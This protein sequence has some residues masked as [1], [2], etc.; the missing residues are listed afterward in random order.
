M[1]DVAARVKFSDPRVTA[2][3]EERASVALQALE[4]LWFNTGTLCNITCAHCYIESS[5]KNDRLGY[6]SVEDV[7]AYLDEIERDGLGTEEIGFTGGEPFMNPDI[8][9]M[10]DDSLA[11]GFRV[12]V[13]TNAMRPMQRAKSKLLQLNQE[14]RKALIL[15]VSLDHYTAARHDEERG[16]HAFRSAL[17][18]LVWATQNGFQATVAGRTVWGESRRP[19][20]AA[21]NA[22]T[23]L[24]SSRQ[25]TY[26]SRAPQGS[27][28]V[29]CARVSYTTASSSRSQSMACRSGPRHAC[30][31]PGSPPVW[32]PQSCR[33]RS[34]PCGQLHDVSGTISTSSLT[35]TRAR[36]AAGPHKVTSASS[37]RRR[38]ADHRV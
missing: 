23:R 22:A 1:V 15:R 7:C 20:S 6:L 30:V 12:T 3:G 32:Q 11:R 26:R 4:T 9:E 25:S 38:L 36:K 5:P 31:H 24:G 21:R 34:M 18:G 16:S 33:Q 13:L 19:D 17:E 2:K 29:S 10:L 14:L 27:R 35:G 8:F 37:R 28:S